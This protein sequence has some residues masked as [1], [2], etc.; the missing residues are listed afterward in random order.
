MNQVQMLAYNNCEMTKAAVESVLAQTIPVNLTVVN[1]GSTDDTAKM[2]KS[3]P[4]INAVNYDQNLSPTSVSNFYLQHHFYMKDCDYILCMGND[5]V[6]PPTFYEEILKWP[7]GIIAASEI[8]ERPAYDEHV[9]DI[10]PVTAI[11]ENTPMA[12]LLLRKWCYD[13]V[14]ARDGYFFDEGMFHYASDCDLALRIASCGIR[15]IQLSLPYWH[16]SSAAIRLTTPEK[17]IPM[18]MQA[19]KDRDFFIRKWGF[20]VDAYE[21]GACARDLNFKG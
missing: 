7:R 11:S 2:L 12:I 21:Y 8:K 5:I 14:I 15:G 18:H 20:P 3:F 1:N 4:S 10:P 16:Y 13:A 19:D 9:R 6:L 17:A